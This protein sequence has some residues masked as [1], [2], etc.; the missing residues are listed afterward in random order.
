LVK[1]GQDDEK[2]FPNPEAFEAYRKSKQTDEA[3]ATLDIM[4]WL[5]RL[6]LDIIGIGQSALSFSTARLAF[7]LTASP[8]FSW[9]RLHL[10]FPEPLHECAR[11]RFRWNVLSLGDEE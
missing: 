5:S 10:R 11:L 4:P 2:G 6:T 8:S 7:E 9:F 3:E 1:T